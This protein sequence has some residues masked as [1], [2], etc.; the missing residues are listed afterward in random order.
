MEQV[1]I[2][3][4]IAKIKNNK[5]EI[6]QEHLYSIS[7]SAK[8]IFVIFFSTAISVHSSTNLSTNFFLYL[9]FSYSKSSP[10]SHDLSNSLSQ[11][12]RF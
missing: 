12:L 1:P 3:M 9:Q 5:L 7:H 6:V 4:L 2:P 11:L 10:I 8:V